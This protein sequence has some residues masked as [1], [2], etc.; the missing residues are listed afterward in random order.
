MARGEA[1]SDSD[2]TGPERLREAGELNVELRNEGS[3]LTTEQTDD[4]PGRLPHADAPTSLGTIATSQG[5]I[6]AGFRQ[7]ID[8]WE[9]YTGEEKTE[10]ESQPELLGLVLI[11]ARDRTPI[12]VRDNSR[13]VRKI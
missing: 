6:P 7:D 10:E 8:G 4:S 13:S 5:N 3:T 9:S 12:T 1:A 11:E 2:T